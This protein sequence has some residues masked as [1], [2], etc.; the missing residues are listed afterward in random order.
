MKPTKVHPYPRVGVAVLIV[1]DGK[2]L[3]GLRSGPH[4]NNTWGTP[5]GKLDMGETWVKCAERETLEESGIKISNLRY[6][7][8]TEDVHVEEGLHFITIFMLAN[9]ES[10]EPRILEP[11][12]IAEWGWFEYNNLPSPIFLSIKS[13]REQ[14]PDQLPI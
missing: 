6:L 12:R 7:A 9:W 1:R 14:Y 4:G 3:L 13:L 8:T 5:G 10:G 2:I 11:H